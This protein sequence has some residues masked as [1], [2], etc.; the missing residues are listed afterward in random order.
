MKLTKQYINKEYHNGLGGIKK[1]QKYQF[2]LRL[3][4]IA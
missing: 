3:Q 2:D 1:W 4:E